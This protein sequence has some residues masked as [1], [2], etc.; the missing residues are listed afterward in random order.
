MDVIINR[1]AFFPRNSVISIKY[2]DRFSN[3]MTM[4][5]SMSR[6]NRIPMDCVLS[7]VEKGTNQNIGMKANLNRNYVLIL[8]FFSLVDSDKSRVRRCFFDMRNGP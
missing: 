5:L 4:G 6:P 8:Y 1:R 3:D 7:I 2:G